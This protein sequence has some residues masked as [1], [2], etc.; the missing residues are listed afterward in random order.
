MSKYIAM[1]G[2]LSEGYLPVGPFDSFDD[3]C[4]WAYRNANR[5]NWIMEVTEPSE[6]KPEMLET[7]HEDN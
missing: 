1:F 5:E 3:A 4:D 2:N 7:A 6:Y